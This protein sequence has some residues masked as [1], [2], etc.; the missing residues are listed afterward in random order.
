MLANGAE[1]RSLSNNLWVSRRSRSMPAAYSG[2][3][4]TCGVTWLG[5]S[6]WNAR[7]D[8]AWLLIAA[9]ISSTRMP[10]FS[11]RG[12]RNQVSGAPASPVPASDSGAWSSLSQAARARV[13]RGEGFG[14]ATSDGLIDA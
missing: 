7:R 10:A 3:A 14:I 11:A 1:R 12:P 6:G 2:E 9:T 13:R 4:R 5:S 8:S